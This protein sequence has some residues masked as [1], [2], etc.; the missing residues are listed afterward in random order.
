MAARGNRTRKRYQ[1]RLN[2]HDGMGALWDWLMSV[3]EGSRAHELICAANLGVQVARGASQGA[4]TAALPSSPAAVPVRLS[5]T[6]A[7]SQVG[8]QPPELRSLDPVGAAS[9]SAG[10]VGWDLSSSFDEVAPTH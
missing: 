3:P 2:L 10:M 9:A 8:V 1:A 5:G 7:S 4:V 6:E